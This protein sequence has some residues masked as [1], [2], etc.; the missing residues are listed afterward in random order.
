MLAKLDGEALIAMTLINGTGMEAGVAR[1]CAV[2]ITEY[3]K[4]RS[5]PY[6]R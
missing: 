2:P 5:S 1:S 3:S 6:N 4:E